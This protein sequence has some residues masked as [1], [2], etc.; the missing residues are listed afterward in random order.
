MIEGLWNV[1]AG[2]IFKIKLSEHHDVTATTR[3]CAQ[4]RLGL[5]FAVPLTRDASGRIE[6]VNEAA[7][8]VRRPLMQK[9]AR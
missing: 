8:P 9:R 2:T 7:A 1:P 6:A 4:D 5:E 3:W